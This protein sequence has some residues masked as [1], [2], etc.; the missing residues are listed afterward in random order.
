MVRGRN[1][2]QWKVTGNVSIDTE[3]SLNGSSGSQ[4]TYSG[5]AG[6]GGWDS[7]RGMLNT[8]ANS[9]EHPAMDGQGPG[10]GRGFEEFRSNGGGGY[11]GQ[12]TGGLFGGTGGSTYGDEVITYLF[13]GSGGGH[14][15]TG[16]GNSGG[17]GGA[18]GIQSDGNLT[19]G[20]N[21]LV[22]VDGGNGLYAGDRS[23]AAGSG[24]S[25][26][27]KAANI[28]NSGTLSAKGGNALIMSSGGAGGAGRIAL[29]TPGNLTQGTLDV[30]GGEIVRDTISGALRSEDLV[31]HWKFE[32]S[33]VFNT[34]TDSGPNG[35]D[36]TIT[37]SPAR[38][39]GMIGNAFRFDGND[40]R[41]VIP[42]NSAMHL[43]KY[44]VSFWVYPEKNNEGNTGLFG[45]GGR[46]YA[47][48]LLN[49]N[50]ATRGV[51]HHRF[52]EGTNTNNGVAN[53][54]LSAWNKWVHVVGTNQGL[55]GTAATYLDGILVQQKN[56]TDVLGVNTTA[57]LNIGVVPDNVNSD[58]GYFLGIIDDV[59]LYG[60]AL[61]PDEVYYLYQGDMGLTERAPLTAAR[62]AG[63]G[64]T[65]IVQMPSVSNPAVTTATYGQPFSTSTSAGYGVTYEFTGLPPGLDTRE[66]YSPANIPSTLAWY[67][68]DDNSSTEIEYG[69]IGTGM[70]VSLWEDKSGNGNHA[71]GFGSP[72]FVSNGLNGMPVI[73]YSGTD[74]EYHS[75][76][77][78]TDIRTV[79]WVVKRNSGPSFLLGDNNQFHFH[80]QGSTFFQGNTHTNVSNGA[81]AINGTTANGT[82][83]NIPATMS[84]ISLRTTGNVEASNFS[85]DRNIAGRYWNGD[86]AE[87]LIYNTPLADA[88]ISKTEGYLAHKWGL[89]SD[90]QGSHPYQASAPVSWGPS[91]LNPSLWLDANDTGY[92]ASKDH[93]VKTWKDISGNGRDATTTDFS[94]GPTIIPNQL[95]GKP[96][97]RF[98]M[99]ETL[100]ISDPRP[101][102]MTIYIVGKQY[103]DAGANR[104][105]F[106]YQGWRL[107]HNGNWRLMRYNNN[108]PSLNS[109]KPSGVYSMVGWRVKRYDF[110]MW[111][112]G[113]PG[114]SSTS[115]QWHQNVLFDRINFDSGWE[116]GEIMMVQD[117]M[118]ESDRLQLEGY[119]AHKWGLITSLPSTHPYKSEPPH[120]PQGPNITG[121]PTSA[122]AFPVT[123]KATNI[124]GSDTNTFT[125]TVDPAMPRALTLAGT[126]VV[127]TGARLNGS[128][129]DSGGEPSI[130]SFDWGL[131]DSV[132]DQNLT[133]PGTHNVGSFSGFLT[134]L[135][136]ATTYFYRA[137][138]TNGAGSSLGKDVSSLPLFQW[139]LDDLG[140]SAMDQMGQAHGQINGA[141]SVIDG[142]RGRV[143][144]FDGNDDFVNLG[145]IDVMDNIERFTFS[146]WFKRDSDIAGASPIATNHEINNVLL[147]QSS[148]A[149]NDNLEIGT[150]GTKVEI[151]IDSGSGTSDGT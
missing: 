130:A 123:V 24:G 1:S 94:T 12:G 67:T 115:N 85:N 56:I 98:N 132:L 2:L 127:S 55:G 51:I 25:I 75:W 22:S 14:G 54:N 133:L 58:S 102:P 8:D 64:T 35:L 81:L 149:S 52:H 34:A 77:N 126:E 36:G 97:V 134:G 61:P 4:G 60:K 21:G 128:L 27:L 69:T 47:F 135:Q 114:G 140:S 49:S 129:H 43:E 101:M 125:L 6:P 142:T 92:L 68:A 89:A 74:G 146:V 148:S 19:I 103:D 40:D 116:L 93:Y 110:A 63:A 144:H 7:G 91:D 100:T 120:G 41:V 141:N 42:N 87:L 88:D 82:I 32:E 106:T 121:I 13:G 16:T 31:G 5:R 38:V 33:I 9:N 76:S 112:N 122:G 83:A 107:A 26:R 10:G 48:W 113:E 150:E 53:V 118:D 105:L 46:N 108:A 138:A 119:L 23:G 86:L 30:T 84:V 39:P 17:G 95:N 71:T 50:H 59:R 147:A 37:G 66:P 20:S 72:S 131:S 57:P 104:E 45:R 11:G 96:L 29:L 143:L 73:R 65:A 79:F 70:R 44:T 78:M 99:G 124:W 3:I 139:K 151:Y 80:S 111:V 136:P 15:A 90:L 145:D 137:K 18:I 62:Q 109:A 117:K 28:S